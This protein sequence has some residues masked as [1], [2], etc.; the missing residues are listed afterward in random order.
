MLTWYD[1]PQTDHTGKVVCVSYRAD[2]PHWGEVSIRPHPEHPG[3]MVLDC[4]GLGI[5]THSL[6]TVM[7]ED[8]LGPAEMALMEALVQRG[9]WCLEA[10]AVIGCPGS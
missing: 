9:I 8:A 1:T 3:E 6:G 4:P 5:E 10:L 2:I 7:A